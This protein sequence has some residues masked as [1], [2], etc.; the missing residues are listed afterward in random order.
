[1]VRQQVSQSL[2]KLG[3]GSRASE[4]TLS[5]PTSPSDDLQ[6]QL[7]AILC[8]R[9]CRNRPLTQRRLFRSYFSLV[10]EYFS[11]RTRRLIYTTMS[12]T[13][14][15]PKAPASKPAV[16]KKASAP[17]PPK[18]HPKYEDM[19]T[20][21]ELLDSL[22][23]LLTVSYILSSNFISIIR[24]HRLQNT[25][26]VDGPHLSWSTASYQEGWRRENRCFSPSHQEVR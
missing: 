4:N 20:V 3:E 11:L 7:E 10:V 13:D 17:R 22:S 14:K 26:A 18:T 2:G 24:L 9:S 21:S 12:T 8:S 23:T 6:D 25:L 1:M 19:V 16:E 5:S 15:S